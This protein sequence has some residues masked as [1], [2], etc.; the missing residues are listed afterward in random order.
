MCEIEIENERETDRNTDRQIENKPTATRSK[1]I[2]KIYE[3]N[4]KKKQTQKICQN[5]NEVIVQH[6]KNDSG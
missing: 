3:F 5:S 6:K 2:V 1:E 4:V